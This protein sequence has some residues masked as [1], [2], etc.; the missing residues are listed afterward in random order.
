MKVTV[1]CPIYENFILLKTD[2][3]IMSIFTRDFLKMYRV[4]TGSIFKNALVYDNP[5]LDPK[6]FDDESLIEKLKK[7]SVSNQHEKAS[8]YPVHVLDDGT[9]MKIMV[10][11]ASSEYYHVLFDKLLILVPKQLSNN[12]EEIRDVIEKVNG[13]N[14]Y[15][16]SGGTLYAFFYWLTENGLNFTQVSEYD[17]RSY[18]VNVADLR[19]NLL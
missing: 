4:N 14:P 11:E 6:E 12:L 10:I 7:V 16:I 8:Y 3:Y 18:S 5:H 13:F 1:S 17:R 19:M 15:Y 2:G 9:L